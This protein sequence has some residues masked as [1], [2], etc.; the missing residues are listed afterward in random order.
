[1]ARRDHQLLPG[2]LGL[3][4]LQYHR[5]HPDLLLRGRHG[6]GPLRVRVRRLPRRRTGRHRRRLRL[7]LLLQ[8]HLLRHHQQRLLDEHHHLGVR[9]RRPRRRDY[10]DAQRDTRDARRA[11]LMELQV[12][13]VR[14]RRD[15]HRIHGH[16]LR[17][18]VQLRDQH[19]R[20]PARRHDVDRRLLALL[21]RGQHSELLRRG[22]VHSRAVRLVRRWRRRRDSRQLAGQLQ[23]HAVRLRVRVRGQAVRARQPDRRRR[24]LRDRVTG[25]LLREHYLG[26]GRQR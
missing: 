7:V 17:L 24:R 3:R 10:P 1:M 15:H 22:G 5:A 18:L 4:L 2:I 16:R 25:E 21:L 8:L 14:A 12:R 26:L 6:S 13:H 11:F 20:H 23:R 19:D 9:W